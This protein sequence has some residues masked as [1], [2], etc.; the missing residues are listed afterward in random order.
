VGKIKEIVD[1]VIFL[2]SRKS[3]YI[4]GQIIYVDGGSTAYVPMTKSDFAG[5]E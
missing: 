5:K 4:T 3:S 2:C 1:P